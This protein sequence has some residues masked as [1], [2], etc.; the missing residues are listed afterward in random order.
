MKKKTLV[1]PLMI[2][3]LLQGCVTVGASKTLV[4]PIS[5]EQKNIFVT[6]NA[7]VHCQDFLIFF[8]CNIAVDVQ[9]I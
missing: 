2:L 3:S 6:S 5:P 9:Q 4:V 8:R 1:L 7:T